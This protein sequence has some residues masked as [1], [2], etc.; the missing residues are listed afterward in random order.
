MS[1]A[2]HPNQLRPGDHVREYRLLRRL[3]VGGFSMVF[4]AERGRHYYALK[5]ALQPASDADEDRVDGWLRREAVSLEHLVHPNLL[6]VHEWGRWPEPRTGY[7]FYVTDYV[8]GV[9]FI[10]WCRRGRVAPFEW[11]D[12]LCEVL[13]PLEAMHARGM[14]HRDIKA[15]NVLVRDGDSRPF[16]IDFGAVHLPCAPPLTE[17]IAPG[18]MYCQ[19]PEAIR[20]VMS[21]EAREKG[22]RFEAHPSADL[23]AV[24]VLL[25]EALTGHHPFDPKL[26][27]DQLLVAIL[28]QPPV[29]PRLLNPEAPASLCS[30]AMRLLAK[31]PSRRPPSASAV[32]EE[33]QRLR[34]EEGQ[35]PPWRTPGRAFSGQESALVRGRAVR[36]SAGRAGSSAR[37]RGPRRWMKVFLVLMLGMGLLGWGG[38]LLLHAGGGILPR[39][40]STV[41]VSPRPAEQGVQPVPSPLSLPTHF[42]ADTSAE[43]PSRACALLRV[44]LGTTLV[45]FV[46]CA[47]AP[48]VRPDPSG[49]LKRCPP[50]AIETPQKLGFLPDYM[51]DS[52]IQPG[53][54]VSSVSRR[55]PLTEG[56]GLNVKPGPITAHMYPFEGED[57][58]Y[59]VIAGQAVTT[60]MRVYIE[61]DRVQLPDGTWLPFCGAA[62]S[63]A[64]MVYGLLT[65]EAFSFPNVLVDPA[66]V[67]HGPGSVVLNDPQFM[68]AV[69]PPKGERRRFDIEQVDPEAKPDIRVNQ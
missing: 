43:V 64:E 33:L 45:Q 50:E 63:T 57:S 12:V 48:T 38:W 52:Y 8:P 11:V 36:G 49:Y 46:G 23:Y 13:R 40:E 34:A 21:Q 24:G 6:P 22:A 65:R 3:G 62:V 15:D 14:C 18:T 41:P 25:Y 44:L 27:V 26:P 69:E 54:S 60:R 61:F 59:L 68:T 7:S 19:P 66:L 29:E 37:E 28:T 20:F 53:P 17:G 16:L 5:V 67:D 30:L 1:K 2:L 31:E 4:L 32:R 39:V 35:S 58:R 42:A 56:G 9:T 55:K 51:Y 47:T 10:E